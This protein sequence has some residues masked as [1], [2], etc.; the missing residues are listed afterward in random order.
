M[1]PRALGRDTTATVIHWDAIV[2]SMPVA[3][4]VFGS[5]GAPTP[6]K[7]PNIRRFHYMAFRSQRSRGV[8]VGANL[9]GTLMTRLRIPADATPTTGTPLPEILLSML[10]SYDVMRMQAAADGYNLGRGDGGIGSA[11]I[12]AAHLFGCATTDLYSDSPGLIDSHQ[13]GTVPPESVLA[14]GKIHIAADYAIA[15]SWEAGLELN[16]AG[17]PLAVA[18]SIPGSM[19]NCDAAGSFR[20]RGGIVGGHEYQ[21]IDHD[22]DLNLAWIGQCWPQWGERS[23]DPAYAPRGGFT[24]IGTCPLDELARWFSPSAMSNGESEITV[25]NTVVGFAPPI[26]DLGDW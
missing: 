16:A 5:I 25:A 7:S 10:Y 12:K 8:C 26:L 15:D 6:R 21:L 20:M 2:A 24:Q 11:A 1:G 22:Q 18:S 3:P 14:F 17:F 9:S 13:N 4:R 23:A 19:M